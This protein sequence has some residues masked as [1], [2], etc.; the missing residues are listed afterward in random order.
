[1]GETNLK[2]FQPIHGEEREIER[3]ER[4]ERERERKEREGESLTIQKRQVEEGENA[5]WDFLPFL[6]EI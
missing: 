2:L 5:I 3:K 6:S 1:M 4:E